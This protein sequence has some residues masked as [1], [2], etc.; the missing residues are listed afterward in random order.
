VG[1]PSVASV[2]VAVGAGRG[3]SQRL[4]AS[5]LPSSSG[6]QQGSEQLPQR[7]SNANERVEEADTDLRIYRAR[8]KARD[9]DREA[10]RGRK[11]ALYKQSEG[12]FRQVIRSR[13][14]CGRAYVGLAKTLERQQ[15]IELA[16]QVLEDGCAATKGENAHIWQVWAC[17]EA[18]RGDAKRA[19]QYF[20]AAIAADKTLISAYHSWA[21]L[22]Q[23]QGNLAKARQLLVK[24]LAAAEHVKKPKSHVYVALARLCERS[25]DPQAARAWYKLGV[26]SGNFRDCGPA[27][28]SWASL[29][30]RTGNEKL[31]RELFQKALKGAKSRYAWLSLG[32]WEMRWGNLAK[33]REILGEASEL[34]PADGAIAQAYADA[35]T[36]SAG[37]VEADMEVARDLFEKAVAIDDKRNNQR[38]YYAWAL[39][40]WL[41]GKDFDRSRELFQQGIWA[42]PATAQAAKLFSSW[43]HME[44][45]EDQNIELVRS[46]YT[47]AYKI[48]PRST[49]ILLN[50]AKDER[51]IGEEA[52]GLELESLA[53][54]IT[55]DFERRSKAAGAEMGGTTASNSALWPTKVAAEIADAKS[56]TALSIESNSVIV[57]TLTESLESITYSKELDEFVNT[58]NKYFDRQ[59]RKSN[60]RNQNIVI[61]TQN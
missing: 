31:S 34:F 7:L 49:K 40:E 15:Q 42:G 18:K 5:S 1:S 29:E 59:R 25:D 48:K 22:E 43:A 14:R 30:A 36:K 21:M 39:S 3:E 50:W 35:W 41:L 24:A 20:D 19:R 38:A 10:N 4:R 52:R 8:K 2:A 32:T 61:K 47:C 11:R 55:A 56:L 9:G 44:A 6:Q 54:S 57:R 46:L 60:A 33:G 27:L 51:S 37:K 12:L 26:A 17:L 53:Q 16:V 28:Q 23:R 58:W 13:P 45:V